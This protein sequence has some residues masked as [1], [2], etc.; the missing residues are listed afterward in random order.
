MSDLL[1][2]ESRR[3]EAVGVVKGTS[4]R[5]AELRAE[6]DALT[7]RRD[8]A[9]ALLDQLEADAVAVFTRSRAGYTNGAAEPEAEQAG[10]VSF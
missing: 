7:A 9:L 1:S 2:I 8:E 10:A 6:A 4:A 3:Q 5:L